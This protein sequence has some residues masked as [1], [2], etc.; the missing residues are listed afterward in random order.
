MTHDRASDRPPNGSA[1]SRHSDIPPE[2][3]VPVVEQIDDS[4]LPQ[5]VK[6]RFNRPVSLPREDPDA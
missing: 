2:E 1:R 4:E 6:D 5:S 3:S